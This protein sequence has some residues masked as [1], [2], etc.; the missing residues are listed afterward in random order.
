ASSRNQKIERWQRSVIS[1]GWAGSTSRSRG[2]KAERLLMD[3][4]YHPLFFIALVAVLAPLFN[5][6]PVRLRIPGVVLEIV[7]GIIIGPQ[8]LGLVRPEGAVM[9]LAR[10]GL[11]FLFLLAGMEINLSRLRGPPLKLASYG[12]V[13]SLTL[14]LGAAYVLQAFGLALPPLLVALALT[15]TAI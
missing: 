4:H 9:D 15:T 6:L 8:V 14:A 1:R 7:G 2:D 3:S 13:V 11:C 12:W 5:E 10:V